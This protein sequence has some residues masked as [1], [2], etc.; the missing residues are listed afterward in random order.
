MADKIILVVLHI[1]LFLSV[2]EVHSQTHLSFIRKKLPNNSYVDFSLV[3]NVD[4]NSVQCH[5]QFRNCCRPG[6]GEIVGDWYYP[7]QDRLQFK[8]SIYQHRLGQ[9]VDLRKTFEATSIIG[10]YCCDIP[11]NSSA[12]D[13]LCVGLY[14]NTG[15]YCIPLCQCGVPCLLFKGFIM[16]VDNVMMIVDSDL[17][18]DSPQFTLTCI[19]TGGPATTVTWT[20]DSTTV[21]EGNETVLNDTVTAQYTHTLTVTGRLPGLYRCTVKNNK[22][23]TKSNYFTVQGIS[24]VIKTLCTLKMHDAVLQLPL[25]PVT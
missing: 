15:I 5:T 17:N 9:R 3:G 1:F 23:S 22:P 2:V 4:R 6:K 21:T 20:R 16:R 7:S 19:S 11:Y 18:G 13:T 14:N 10:I 24:L 25:H 12:R 8:G